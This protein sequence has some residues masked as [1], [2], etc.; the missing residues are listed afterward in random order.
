MNLDERWQRRFEATQRRRALKERAVECMGG[1]CRICGIDDPVVLQFHPEDPQEKDFD[2]SSR[3]SWEAIE[4]ELRKC[5]LVCANC[6]CK[7]HAGDH[8]QYFV[9]E[10]EDRSFTLREGE[11]ESSPRTEQLDQPR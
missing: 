11:E 2:V 8:P 4:A 9:L 10:D 5:V 3:M 6:H 1:K 7:I